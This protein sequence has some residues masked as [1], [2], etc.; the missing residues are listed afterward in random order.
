[1]DDFY[2]IV[3]P[4]C[5]T[6]LIVERRTGKIVEVRRPILEES[7]GDRF[8]D[9]FKKVCEREERAEAKFRKALESEKSKKSKLDQLF[10]EK[11]K[12]V[13]ESGADIRPINPYDNE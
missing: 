7:T 9:A 13:E 1:M 4:D 12:E 10:Q 6:I 5:K 2:Q 11:L 3:C 8:E